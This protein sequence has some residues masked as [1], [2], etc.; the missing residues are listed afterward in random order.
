MSSESLVPSPWLIMYTASTI[1][2]ALFLL[3]RVVVRSPSW[4]MAVA[5]GTL[6]ALAVVIAGS[7]WPT[8]WKIP[9]PFV[10]SRAI[11]YAKSAAPTPPWNHGNA[12]PAPRFIATRPAHESR[13]E[14]PSSGFR[15]LWR[16]GINIG[17]AAGAC[18]MAIR[19]GTGWWL[20]RRLLRQ[21]QPAPQCVQK[22]VDEAL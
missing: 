7:C 3:L 21:A 16:H 14:S 5:W 20:T 15:W 18:L 11:S 10:N 2:L 1:V 13:T 8:D 17:L 9:V 12:K 19:H 22:W 6:L 4:R